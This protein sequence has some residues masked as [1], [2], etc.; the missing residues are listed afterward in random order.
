[1][2][3]QGV[4]RL[5]E[6]IADDEPFMFSRVSVVGD[7]WEMPSRNRVLEVDTGTD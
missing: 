6:H 7:N 1:M 2:K 3:D 4:S 5:M